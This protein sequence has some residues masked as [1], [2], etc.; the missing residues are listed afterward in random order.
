MLTN[1]NG[2]PRPLDVL[3]YCRRSV[4]PERSAS[5]SKAMLR[6][7]GCRGTG[8]DVAT[9]AFLRANTS[10]FA[11]QPVI[12]CRSIR[13]ATSFI[14]HIG[15]L[16]NLLFDPGLCEPW[17]VSDRGCERHNLPLYSKLCSRSPQRLS[18]RNIHPVKSI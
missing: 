2:A 10:S 1:R 6:N 3:G 9:L 15:A 18:S 8:K 11:L 13:R 16:A 5:L 4:P 12:L 17:C 14:Q 7:N